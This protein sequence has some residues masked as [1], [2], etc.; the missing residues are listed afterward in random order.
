M[1][2]RLSGNVI[3]NAIGAAVGS[4]AALVSA[5]LIFRVLGPEAYGFV[6]LYVL[7]QGLMPLF[8]LGI[9][10]A[11][12]RAVA[13]HRGR[14]ELGSVAWLLRLAH[15][16]L[17]VVS[18]L[19]VLVVAATADTI[20]A[21]W[22]QPGEISPDEA[23]DALTLMA[24]ALG[25]RVFGVLNRAALMAMEQQ[26]SS[27]LVQSL[28]VLAR[29]LGALGF[30]WATST[31]ITGFLAF[32]VPVSFAEWVCC[33]FIL[34]RCLPEA[35]T[36]IPRAQLSVH[37]R[38]AIR[39]AGLSALW[40][41]ASQF[42][43][44]MLSRTLPLD[45]YGSFSLGVHLATIVP[46]GV[47]ALHAAVQPRLTRLYGAGDPDAASRLYGLATTFTLGISLALLA[48][49]LVA[50]HVWV[51]MVSGAARTRIDPFFVGMWYAF[52][53]VA[54]SVLGL[55]YILQSARGSLRLH[56]A[57][58]VLHTF[59]VVPLVLLLGNESR[60]L[61]LVVCSA[62]LHWLFVL[63][64]L[65]LAHRRFLP[66]GHW[67]WVRRSVFP[68]VMVALPAIA[69]LWCMSAVAE[70]LWSSA[71]LGTFG[72]VTIFVAACSADRE[73]REFARGWMG[74]RHA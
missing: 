5:P 48:A 65:P 3:A 8:D 24:V 10:P 67:H 15:L 12:S 21:F 18:L 59:L 60:V 69:I 54:L 47:A 1:R 7:A 51:P 34:R 35:A 42:D 13:W 71:A 29:T 28:S 9:T 2:G 32:Q 6:G 23:A 66:G 63:F 70:S 11:L 68:P 19:F 33:F 74:R 30:C 40:L 57:M 73:V 26:V 52:G 16:P 64:W 41:L 56:A 37:C 38:F 58:T 36:P 72:A 55:A 53:H 20:T 25:I 61:E 62:L 50:G 45:E 49:F 22:L 39:I 17:L 46:L 14:G 43:K 31:G 27:N 4:A 44:L